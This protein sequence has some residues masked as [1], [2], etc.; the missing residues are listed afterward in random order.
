MF[1]VIVIVTVVTVVV[2]AI[3]MSVPVIVV[4]SHVIGA[5]S[6]DCHRLAHL[7][8]THAVAKFARPRNRV[9]V[10]SGSAW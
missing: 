3:I 10:G 4:T 7:W 8:V 2:M 6:T 1:V 5:L 9:L